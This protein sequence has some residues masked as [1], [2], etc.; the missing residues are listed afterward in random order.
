MFLSVLPEFM[1]CCEV[2]SNFDARE[3]L[4]HTL[5]VPCSLKDKGAVDFLTAQFCSTGL[6]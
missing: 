6:L 4:L 5:S 3:I 1:F 2:F